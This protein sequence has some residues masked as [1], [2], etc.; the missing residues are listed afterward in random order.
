MFSHMTTI[1]LL[2]HSQ[3]RIVFSNSYKLTKL[4]ISLPSIGV[5]CE[6]FAF[7][8]EDCKYESFNLDKEMGTTY[9]FI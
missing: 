8:R 2:F 5:G 3:N 1:K 9:L 7:I 4:K 6:T